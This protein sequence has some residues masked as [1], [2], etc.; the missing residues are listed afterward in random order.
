MVVEGAGLATTA[1][2]ALSTVEGSGD[3]VARG[4]SRGGFGKGGSSERPVAPAKGSARC[5]GGGT[6]RASETDE[7]GATSRRLRLCRDANG[8]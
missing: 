4:C 5:L 1:G 3:A 8:T 7:D 2:V 6:K